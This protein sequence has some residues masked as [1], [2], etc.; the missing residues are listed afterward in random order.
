[1]GEYKPT[2][3][4]TLKTNVDFRLVSVGSKNT[5]VWKDGR[6]ERVTDRKLEK[7]QKSN[8]WTTDF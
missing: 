6:S 8:S 7:L 1:M 4:D 3:I 5:I 2:E